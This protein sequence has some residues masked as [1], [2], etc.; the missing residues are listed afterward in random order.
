MPNSEA[1]YQQVGKDYD[2][3]V[4]YNSKINLYDTVEANENFYIG[5]QWEGV[6]SNGLPTPVFNFL[7]RVVPFAVSSVTTDNLKLQ[8]SP[9]PGTSAYAIR[10][11]EQFAEVINQQFES[12]VEANSLVTLIREYMRN[13]AVDGDGCMHTYF[14]PDIE[15]GQSAKGAIC[16][17]IVENTRV[18]FGNPNNREVQ[19]QPYINFFSSGR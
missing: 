15:T 5:K 6:T 12:I 10:V 18:F 2:A 16:T 7:K 14:N 8:A 4:A 11:V 17:E 3:A 19:R 13:S 9:L 1:L